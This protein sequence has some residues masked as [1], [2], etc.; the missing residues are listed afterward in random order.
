MQINKK[1]ALAFWKDVYGTEQKVRDFAGREMAMGAYGQK[2]SRYAWN[3]DHIVPKACGGTNDTHNLQCCHVDT[4]T[5]KADHFPNF[6]TNQKS[7]AIKKTSGGRYAVYPQKAQ[8]CSIKKDPETPK[9]LPKKDALAS[10]K[11]S[12][13][14]KKRLHLAYRIGKAEGLVKTVLALKES[15][16]SDAQTARI[17]SKL[18]DL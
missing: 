17:L 3:I 13:L 6:T 5:E 15:G 18:Y 10:R 4:N 1:N 12:L 11:K 8:K 2:G 7:F 14:F 16:C 9:P